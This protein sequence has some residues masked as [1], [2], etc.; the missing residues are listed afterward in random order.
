MHSVTG[1]R[2]SRAIPA[3]STAEAG[4][5]AAHLDSPPARPGMLA[6]AVALRCAQS[7]PCQPGSHLQ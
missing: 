6:S 2:N 5:R 7:M 1:V 4:A 3:L